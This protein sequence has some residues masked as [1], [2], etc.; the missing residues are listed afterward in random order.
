MTTSK[1]WGWPKNI[2]YTAK[3]ATKEIKQK[4][5]DEVTLE[6]KAE[7]NEIKNLRKCLAP[8]TLKSLIA[9]KPQKYKIDNNVT[10]QSKNK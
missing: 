8:R 1:N 7:F 9:V 4:I 3:L 2:T 6:C 5:L 10:Q